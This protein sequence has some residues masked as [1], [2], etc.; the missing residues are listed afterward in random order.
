[1]RYRRVLTTRERA[2]VVAIA[3][4][5]ALVVLGFV[6]YL[7]WPSHLPVLAGHPPLY[8]VVAVTGCVF[9]V[10]LQLLQLVGTAI[11]LNFA[12]R[13][14]DPVPMV[15]Q[16]GL[17]VAMLTT[18]FPGSEPWEVA[19]RTLLRFM[20]QDYDGRVDA[21]ILDEGNDPY[22]RERC[23]ALGIHH[24]SRAGVPAWN[25]ESGPYRART[26]HGNHNAWRAAHEHSYDVVTQMD[27]DHV[28]LDTNDFLQ[29]ML[30]YFADPDVAFV[31]APQVYGNGGTS[32]IARGAAELA[33]GFHGVTQRG[34][35]AL[36]A[37]VLIGTNHAYRPTAWDQIGGYQD[38]IIEDHLTA[39]RVPTE[40]NPATGRRWKGVYTPDILTVG[41]GPTSWSD[42]FSQQ[43]RWAYG[44]FEI[45]TRH[46]PRLLPRLTWGQRAAYLS[47][48]FHYPAIGATWLLG[49]ALS[50]M[51]LVA[52]V[53]SSRLQFVP[54]LVFLVTSIVLGLSVNFWLRRFN[55]MPHERA[56]WGMTGML[57]NLV[58][59]PVY[60]AAGF[61][62]LTGR[63]LG[64]KVTAKGRL[65][66]GDHLQTFRLHV[67]W[68]VFATACVVLGLVQGNLYPTLYVWEGVT[69]L[70]VLTPVAIWW[71]H[72]RRELSSSQGPALELDLRSPAA[73]AD[74]ELDELVLQEQRRSGPRG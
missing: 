35:N 63:R 26:K 43:R 54:W 66:T 14:Q 13:A 61:Q 38:C 50:A 64:Y 18:I 25:Q 56:S 37:A 17:R 30:G 23:R 49:N 42:F 40:T 45:L 39:M 72:R 27:P 31:V 33:Y 47:L 19:E 6:A 53:S 68:A 2:S 4:A 57:L 73:S 9:I 59:T 12:F 16:P 48:Q 52:G 55:L 65:T 28:P 62:Q 34:A 60:L 1:M 3:A 36:G 51:Y 15:A 10:T 24:F 5:H 67:N 32:L 58:T 69:I 74:L 70:T 20:E 7:L 71:V 21:W 22:I 46:T 41:E 44:I 29:R 11:N 8:Q